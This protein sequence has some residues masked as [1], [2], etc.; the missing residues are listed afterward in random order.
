MFAALFDVL[1]MLAE[2]ANMERSKELLLYGLQL[3]WSVHCRLNF[4]YATI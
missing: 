4:A 1:L 3:M 2:S